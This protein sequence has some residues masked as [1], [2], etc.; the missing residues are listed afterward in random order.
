MLRL[1]VIFD[2]KIKAHTHKIALVYHWHWIIFR[3]YSRPQWPTAK[4]KS[5]TTW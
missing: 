3:N 4:R 1:K 5:R 2:W